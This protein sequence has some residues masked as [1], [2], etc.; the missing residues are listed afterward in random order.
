MS[1][2]AVYEHTR[3]GVF[4]DVGGADGLVHLSELSW[5]RTPKSPHE[6][7]RVGKK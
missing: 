2:V 3:F 4:V 7:F 5:E 1:S 6:M